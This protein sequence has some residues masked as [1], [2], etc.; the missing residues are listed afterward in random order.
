MQHYTKWPP[1][2]VNNWLVNIEREQT[3]DK[4]KLDVVEVFHEKNRKI[5]IR[6]VMIFQIRDLIQMLIREGLKMLQLL[7]LECAWGA[8]GALC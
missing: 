4:R 1:D 8:W 7:W 5:I 2:K 3:R 6:G